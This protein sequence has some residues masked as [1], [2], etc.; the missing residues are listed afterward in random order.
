MQSTDASH[1]QGD[2]KSALLL[3]GDFAADSPEPMPNDEATETSPL[4]QETNGGDSTTE[5][6]NSE[7]IIPEPQLVLAFVPVL[8]RTAASTWAAI[9]NNRTYVG[10]F[11]GFTA[12]V[13]TITLVL[14]T[15]VDKVLIDASDFVV[16]DLELLDITEQGVTVHVVGSLK[17]DY[18]QVNWFLKTLVIPL[19]AATGT[20]VV[21]FTDSI[22]VFINLPQSPDEHFYNP[23]K[24][25]PFSLPINFSPNAINQSLEVTAAAIVNPYDATKVYNEFLLVKQILKKP[26][27]QVSAVVQCEVKTNKLGKSWGP[28]KVNTRR[29]VT[30]S[31]TQ[32]A[33]PGYELTEYAVTPGNDKVLT[34]VEII[35]DP[36]P[37]PA[38][39]KIAEIEWDIYIPGCENNLLY[40]A[41]ME[42]SKILIS[43]VEPVAISTKG[44]VPELSKKL[45]KFCTDGISPV[46]KIAIKLLEDEGTF[47]VKARAM[48]ELNSS[49][50]KWLYA[51]L[52]NNFQPVTFDIKDM[53]KL[54][55]GDLNYEI[56]SANVVIPN[57][58]DLLPG[59][60]SDIRVALDLPFDNTDDSLF[61]L[62]RVFGDLCFIYDDEIFMKIYLNSWQ[63]VNTQGSTL[64]LSLR[65]S[66]IDIINDKIVSEVLL[67]YL[68]GQKLDIIG[69]ALLDLDITTPICSTIF[70]RMEQQVNISVAGESGIIDSLGIK[71]NGL[72]Y[73]KSSTDSQ[74]RF[75]V[76]AE[77]NN[78]L[79][80]GGA[81]QFISLLVDYN[82]TTFG[83]IELAETAIESLH[84][85]NVTPI[86]RFKAIDDSS[87]D[88]IN[89]L[90]SEYISGH[91]PEIIIKGHDKSSR[92]PAI[93][94]IAS[95]LSIP[96]QIPSFGSED[97][98]GFILATTFHLLTSQVEVTVYN[99]ISNQFGVLSIKDAKTMYEDIDIAY[100]ERA[101]LIKIPPGVSTTQK[102][103]V[104]IATGAAGDILRRAINSNI[105]LHTAASFELVIGEFL[106]DLK[107]EGEGVDAVIKL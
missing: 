86:V 75:F 101:P 6:V 67:R 61:N 41:T 82:G 104:R 27:V 80:A 36:L 47:F 93:A 42:S 29:E 13:I 5:R 57:D 40:V 21:E 34:E 105:T 39:A 107:Y 98:S 9:K 26:T 58:P 11:V 68:D 43:G 97:H 28:W 106:L 52:T 102:I 30:L 51:F 2:S 74:L 32:T 69:K 20:A 17:W 33:L 3:S 22:S 78:T 64:D 25:E 65:N 12:F 53:L 92:V 100:I 37:F 96:F 62:T 16:T 10:I 91:E 54:P 23:F 48:S 89:S 14:M 66:K 8:Y 84:A 24:V 87:R 7:S 49:L 18:S 44:V 81:I 88:T 56:Y 70:Q 95:S 45:V 76:N 79:K 59:L 85:S 31:D 60:Y 83:N 35:I 1:T 90:I 72:E 77:V 71:I 46:N 38:H 4:L 15:K 63:N 19:M 50:P 99:P 103:P 94:H 73:M 55:E